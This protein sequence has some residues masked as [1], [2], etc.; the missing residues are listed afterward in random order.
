MLSPNVLGWWLLL[1]LLFLLVLPLLF[2]MMM[3]I[4]FSLLDYET[5]SCIR[6]SCSRSPADFPNSPNTICVCVYVKIELKW[7]IECV[8]Q[9]G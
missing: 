8:P 3:M 5:P 1:L 2:T 4:L 6:I 9:S 7:N